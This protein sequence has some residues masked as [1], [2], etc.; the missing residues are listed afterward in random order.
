MAVEEHVATVLDDT[1]DFS[2]ASTMRHIHDDSDWVFVAVANAAFVLAWAWNSQLTRYCQDPSVWG[3]IESLLNRVV[4]GSHDGQWW[5]RAPGTGDP[6][7][8]RFVLLPLMEAYTHARQKLDAEQRR[9]MLAVIAEATAYQVEEYAGMEV[10]R[11]GEYPNMDAYF[12]LIMEHAARLLNRS[13][14]HHLAREFVDYLESSLFPGGGFTYFKGTNE[15]EVYHRINVMLLARYWELTYSAKALDILRRTLPY[16]PNVME[17]CGALENYTDPFWKHTWNTAEPH[18]LDVLATLFPDAPEA[19]L[20]R[21]LANTVRLRRNPHSNL[22]LFLPWAVSYWQDE[23]GAPLPDC[24]VRQDASIRGPRGRFG[25]FSWAATTGECLDTLVGAMVATSPDD[26]SS[27]QAAGVEVTL[28]RPVIEDPNSSHAG[29]RHAKAVYITGKEYLRR[30]VCSPTLACVAVSTPIYPGLLAWRENTR[31][32]DWM[33]E[34]VWLMLEDRIVG[35]IVALPGKRPAPARRVGVYFRLGSTES[36]RQVELNH[37]CAGRLHLRVVE[38]SFD[39]CLLAPAYTMW[40]DKEPRS[41]EVLLFSDNSA[42]NFLREHHALV[43]IYP[44]GSSPGKWSCTLQE[45]VMTL[46]GEAGGKR[47]TA[48]FNP[49]AGNADL[50]L[51]NMQVAAWYAGTWWGQ[52]QKPE[53]TPLPEQI[54]AGESIVAT[55]V[56]PQS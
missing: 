14:Y 33:N 19:P 51:A 4:E 46:T 2:R 53:Q 52:D 15:C 42:Q 45:R 56:M 6:N 31:H 27:L 8:N 25:S 35:L 18:V 30:T 16:Y 24:V 29:R 43:E 9:R 38:N 37:F 48:V 17:P 40:Q 1:F 47:A 36:A 41:S 26:V 7:I 5:R 50:D 11:I 54:G 10:R 23:Q 34:Q 49:R 21:H 12:M 32:A 39:S 3:R 20:H 28:E 22:I 44:E 55:G 13:R